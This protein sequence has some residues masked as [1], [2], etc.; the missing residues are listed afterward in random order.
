MWV[1]ESEANISRLFDRYESIARRMD[2]PPVLILDECDQLLGK[3]FPNPERSVDKMHNGM[4]S[5][6]LSRMEQWNGFM[7]LTT[8]LVDEGTFDPA[9]NRR[10]HK[11]IRFPYPSEDM[12]IALW[13]L[14]LK[15]SIPV[16][17]DVDI[18]RL[19]HDF[20]LTGGQIRI[21]IENAATACVVRHKR[22]RLTMED[23]LE[24]SR[25][26]LHNMISA[27]APARRRPVGFCAEPELRT[28]E[29]IRSGR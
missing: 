10:I 21:V 26:E 22:E 2:A 24:A 28:K 11:K 17:D 16:A 9:Y 25:N 27:G 13:K 14:L 19:A 15:P 7:I 3:R 20:E 5:L 8:N 4:Q 29:H 6:L 18:K 1:G 12:R 23:L